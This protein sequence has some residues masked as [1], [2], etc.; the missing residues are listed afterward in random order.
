MKSLDCELTWVIKTE[1]EEVEKEKGQESDESRME[2]SGEEKYLVVSDEV[3]KPTHIA[4]CV[5]GKD[6]WKMQL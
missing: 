2:G 1:L 5:P 3:P 4:E 6:P